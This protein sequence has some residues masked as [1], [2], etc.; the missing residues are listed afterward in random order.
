MPWGGA[1][2]NLIILLLFVLALPAYSAPI[3]ITCTL[4]RDLDEF[5]TMPQ[6]FSYYR[7]GAQIYL[8]DQNGEKVM[9]EEAAAGQVKSLLCGADKGGL[10]LMS[11]GTKA[12]VVDASN[13]TVMGTYTCQ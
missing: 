8:Y 11:K 2:K 6:V 7:D 9:C 5:L 1:M 13:F 12:I 3:E 4:E 10:Y